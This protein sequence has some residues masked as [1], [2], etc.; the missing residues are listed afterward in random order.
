MTDLK[1]TFAS[2]IKSGFSGGGSYKKALVN[3]AKHHNLIYFGSVRSS[4]DE[5]PVIRGSTASTIQKDNHYSIG[6]HAG[7]DLALVDRTSLIGY[8]GYKALPHRWYVIQIDLKVAKNLPYIFVGTKQQTKAY[9]ARV[10]S[11][12]RDLRYLSLTSAAKQINA[13]HGQYAIMASP[14]RMHILYRLFN[15]E[16]IDMMATHRYPFAV[17]IEDESL[18]IITEAVKPSQQLLDKLLHYGL[19]LAKEIDQRLV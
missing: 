14:A 16:T 6:T 11:S 13:F 15:D 12:H 18:S 5:A 10:L 9:Y 8:E 1:P 3:F 2:R 7:Y 19:W 17:E 4:N